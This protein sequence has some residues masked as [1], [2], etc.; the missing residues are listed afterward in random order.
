MKCRKFRNKHTF[1]ISVKGVMD[2]YEKKSEN[3]YDQ[4]IKLFC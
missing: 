1:N 4:H 3:F 2:I